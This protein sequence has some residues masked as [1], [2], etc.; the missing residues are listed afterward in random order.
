MTLI[1]T[2]LV[3][4][5]PTPEDLALRERAPGVSAGEIEAATGAYLLIAGEVPEIRL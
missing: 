4:M 3:V 2:E 1:V 5:E